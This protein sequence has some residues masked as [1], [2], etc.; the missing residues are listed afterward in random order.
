MSSI[1]I[2]V[3]KNINFTNNFL[4]IVRS[5]SD[6]YSMNISTQKNFNHTEPNFHP[7]RLRTSSNGCQTWPRQN[8][9]TQST[10]S[11]FRDHLQI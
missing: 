10:P 9:S 2:L 3:K 6:S 7:D 11:S 5:D 1:E 4:N 8:F